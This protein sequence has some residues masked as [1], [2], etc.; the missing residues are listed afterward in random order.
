MNKIWQEKEIEFLKENYET[1]IRGEI[2]SSLGRSEQ[3]IKNKVKELGLSKK[4]EVV[5]DKE[6]I[7]KNFE[8]ETFKQLANRFGCSSETIKKFCEE[9]GLSKEYKEIEIGTRFG[10]LITS[11]EEYRF[12]NKIVVDCICDC[13]NKRKSAH[14]TT[15]FTGETWNCGCERKKPV[16]RKLTKP[17]PR[18]YEEFKTK[19]KLYSIWR[20]CKRKAGVY[21]EWLDYNNFYD[22]TIKIWK[23]DLVI[24]RKDISKPHSMQNSIFITTKE[25]KKRVFDINPNIYEKIRKTNISKYGYESPLSSK[26]IQNKIQKTNLKKY[27]KK[28]FTETKY[29]IEKSRETCLKKYGVEHYSQTEYCKEK[30]KEAC[31]KKYGVD[32]Q[33]KSRDF[34]NNLKKKNKENGVYKIID[35]KT[36]SEWCKEIGINETSLR[37]R[38]NRYGEEIAI[39][40][41]KK[42][43]GIEIIMS[44]LLDKLGIE[45]KKDQI[46]DRKIPDFLIEDYKLIIEC[47]GLYWHSEAKKDKYYHKEKRE[48]YLKN[49]YAPLFFYEDEII[50]K[51]DII[52]S[53]I[54]NKLGKS[55]RIFARKCNIVELNTKTSSD[56]CDKNHLMGKGSGKGFGLYY[57]NELVCVMRL[58]KKKNGLDISRFCCKNGYSV[59]G[60]FSKILKYVI[61][62]ISPDFI[63]TFT[64]LRYGSGE[65]LK[66]IGFNIESESLSFNW[67]KDDYR[68]HRLS[69]PSN[70]GYKAGFIK[71]W[72]CGQRKWV[73]YNN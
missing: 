15:L 10:K 19:H 23:E 64:D 22:W 62:T 3:S 58:N 39:T 52:E 67:I 16:T 49:G 41:P 55:E 50:K 46:I 38:I 44:E 43:S 60:G 20:D 56:F 27:G 5:I 69:F 66:D 40:K 18:R 21:E 57:E 72:D 51:I 65:Y 8:K 48:T 7:L 1:K 28:H 30:R 29:F 26:E 53:I 14:R 34:V 12:N 13:G 25:F 70:S 61:K 59:I 36:I 35:G 42:I 54:K 11:S 45:Y 4:K 37:E 24:Y 68:L 17:R 73:L 2:A 32:H 6:Y 9:L 63:Q 71:M 33:M 47:D 31:L